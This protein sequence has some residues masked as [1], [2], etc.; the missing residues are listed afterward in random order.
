M[1]TN[2]E[3]KKAYFEMLDNSYMMDSYERLVKGY[4]WMVENGY[5][6]DVRN[7]CEE[8]GLDCVLEIIARRYYNNPMKET[9]MASAHAAYCEAM[10]IRY[11]Q[12]T[13]Q[14]ENI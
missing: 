1:K 2:E 11:N 8:N 6:D 13:R 9:R 12:A 4:G 10:D 7:Y 5:E 14:Y 3:I